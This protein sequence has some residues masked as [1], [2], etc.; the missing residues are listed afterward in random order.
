[1]P[2][3]ANL[4]EQV[5][6]QINDQTSIQ[7]N[8]VEEKPSTGKL[9]P[10]ASADFWLETATGTDG[11]EFISQH[12]PLIS[13]STGV[14]RGGRWSYRHLGQ[15]PNDYDA[16][17]TREFLIDYNKGAFVIPSGAPALTSGDKVKL[18]YSW[19]QEQEYRF[20]DTELDK[21][22]TVGDHYIRDKLAL[23]YTISGYGPN[24]TMHPVPS[25][26]EFSLLVLSTSYFLRR[27]LEEEQLQDG[28]FVKEG[29]TAFDTTKTLV[30]RG[31]SL[32]QVKDDLDDIIKDVIL[33]DLE[34]A[35]QKIDIYSTKDNDWPGG[36]GSDQ[37]L[38]FPGSFIPFSGVDF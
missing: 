30:H 14:L 4:I 31:R 16:S 12:M 23:S 27:R 22:V 36:I 24:L 5:R 11:E 34:S 33:K 38:L 2:T 37:E 3:K 10:Q 21:W 17:T 32:K 8:A 6:F 29:E 7:I 18:S 9:T 13:G 35:G 26:V 20:P 15:F 25:G 28:I 19:S 1:M